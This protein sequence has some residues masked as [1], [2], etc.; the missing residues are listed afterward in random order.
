[1]CATNISTYYYFLIVMDT[2]IYERISIPNTLKSKILL[3][4]NNRCANT[5]LSKIKNMNGYKC[6]LYKYHDGSFQIKQNGKFMCNFD[7]IVPVQLGGTNDEYNIHALCLSCHE[8]KTMND[9]IE[10]RKYK[11]LCGENKELKYQLEHN[12]SKFFDIDQIYKIINENYVS[13]IEYEAQ[14]D[15]IKK[16]EDDIQ[17]MKGIINEHIVNIL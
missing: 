12:Q 8:W 9:N 2:T 5:L 7:H 13:I 17:F 16:L 3:D 6:D 14:L 15:I 11:S 4:Q 10:I 1:M